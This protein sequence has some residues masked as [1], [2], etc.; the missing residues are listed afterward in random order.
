[1]SGV[2][3]AC[4]VHSQ[5]HVFWYLYW[6]CTEFRTSWHSISTT[7]WTNVSINHWGFPTWA[8]INWPCSSLITAAKHHT[9]SWWLSCSLWIHSHLITCSFLWLLLQVFWNTFKSV[10]GVIFLVAAL[11]ALQCTYRYLS[12]SCVL[13][14]GAL[15]EALVIWLNLDGLVPCW[16]ICGA[17][18]SI[19]ARLGSDDRW[20]TKVTYRWKWEGSCDLEWGGCGEMRSSYAKV[21]SR[22]QSTMLW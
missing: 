13:A 16:G 6:I 9:V 7:V 10:S 4:F 19:T 1:L 20:C 14:S 18:S 15:D 5:G 21:A 11:A 8:A 2:S 22:S 17:M 12:C 3:K